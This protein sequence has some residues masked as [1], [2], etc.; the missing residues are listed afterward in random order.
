M[1]RNEKTP[2]CGA[3]NI[4]CYNDAEDELLAN[5]FKEGLLTSG[6]NYRGETQC[7]CLPACTTIAYDAEISQAEYDFKSQF[8]AFMYNEYLERNPE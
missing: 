2:V 8:R 1:P 6:E 7:N 4:K 5:E 3:A